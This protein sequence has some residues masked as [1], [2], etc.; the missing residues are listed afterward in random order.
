MTPKELY[1]WAQARKLE[2]AHIRICDGMAI[3]M[4]PEMECVSAGRYQ[5]IIDVS[6][7]TAIE[8]DDAESWAAIYER[9]EQ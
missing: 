6:T 1:E 2:E 5:V 9:A 4:Y 3:T 7:L 8:Y